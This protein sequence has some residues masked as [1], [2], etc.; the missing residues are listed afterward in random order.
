MATLGFVG[1][2]DIDSLVVVRRELHRAMLTAEADDREAIAG[3]SGR[4]D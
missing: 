1:L 4:T 2:G 3:S